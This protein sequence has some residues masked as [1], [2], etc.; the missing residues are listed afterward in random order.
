MTNRFLVIA[1]LAIGAALAQPVLAQ[2][3]ASSPSPVVEAPAADKASPPA[4][5]PPRKTFRQRRAEA[6]AAREARRREA[7]EAARNPDPT[8]GVYDPVKKPPAKP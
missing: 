5:K 8:G 2:S 1:V 7:V 6:A 3:A 4:A